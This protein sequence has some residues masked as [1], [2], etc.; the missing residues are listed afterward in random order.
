MNGE[1]IKCKREEKGWSQR[2]L[3]DE[4]GVSQNMIHYIET[5]QRIPS[6]AVANALAKA[7]GCKVDDFINFT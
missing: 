7:L 3:G 2:R 1:Y 4:V 5:N 6:L